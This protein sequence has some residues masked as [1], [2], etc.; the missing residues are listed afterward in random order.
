MILPFLLKEI[1]LWKKTSL[2]QGYT[3]LIHFKWGSLWM[4]HRAKFN[5]Q[6]DK[7]EH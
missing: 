7:S 1:E 3:F 2:G 6:I 4:E 5:E